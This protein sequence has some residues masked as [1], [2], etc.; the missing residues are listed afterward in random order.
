MPGRLQGKVALITGAARGQGRS[1]AVTLAREGADI[2]AVDV[3]AQIE[4]V[5]YPM[6]TEADLAETARLVEALDR[7]IVARVADVRDRGPL[8]A[9]VAT[10]VAELGHLDVV[11]ANAGIISLGQGVPPTAFLDVVSVDLVGVINTVEAA[12]PH[13][14]P[15]ASVI[16]IGSMAAMMPGTATG[17]AGAAGYS[18][19]KRGVARFAHDLALAAAP[20]GIRVNAVHPGNIDTD[21][22]QNEAMYRMFR[23]DLEAPTREDVQAAFGSMHALPV[24]TLDPADISEAVLY[25]A[26]DAARYVTGQQLKVDAGALLSVTTAGAPG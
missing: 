6:A 22:L 12:F 8:A 10:G 23:P 24:N 5:P 17:A 16:C 15:G 2:I 13:L 21:M 18:H 1:H 7:R 20:N 4:S 19:A 3:A 26:S 14:G 11:V 25:L 9:A